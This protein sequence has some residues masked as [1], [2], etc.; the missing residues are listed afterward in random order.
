MLEML[1]K[2]E[3]LSDRKVSKTQLEEGKIKVYR[4]CYWQRLKREKRFSRR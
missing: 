2:N 3:T 1:N 4:V